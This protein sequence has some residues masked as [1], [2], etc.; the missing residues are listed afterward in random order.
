MTDRVEWF[1]KQSEA[2]QNKNAAV[3]NFQLGLIFHAYRYREIKWNLASQS[4][5]FLDNQ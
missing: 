5:K 1:G 3:S 4:N 2:K